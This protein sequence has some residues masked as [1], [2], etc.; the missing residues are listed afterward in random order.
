MAV[1]A[2]QLLVVQGS[3]DLAQCR[4]S[5]ACFAYQKNGLLVPEAFVNKD[6][7]PPELPADDKSRNAQPSGHVCKCL[8]KIIFVK[9]GLVE[10]FFVYLGAQCGLD[11]LFD[12]LLVLLAPRSLSQ[13]QVAFK[14]DVLSNHA[15][16]G[17]HPVGPFQEVSDGDG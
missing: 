11:C 4:L 12:E 5:T 17:I 10:L 9:I 8:S 2:E 7:K 13:N 6:C 15:L 1:D 16:I 14:G 3:K